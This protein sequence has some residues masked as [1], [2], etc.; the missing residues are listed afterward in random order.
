MARSCVLLR[1]CFL[2]CYLLSVAE[3]VKSR[4]FLVLFPGH[5]GKPERVATLLPSL[6]YYNNSYFDCL[7]MVHPSE[8]VVHDEAYA[9]CEV[10]HVK[11]PIDISGLIKLVDPEYI[12][13]NKYAAVVM[14][15]DDIVVGQDYDPLDLVFFM[16]LYELEVASPLVLGSYHEIQN[17]VVSP[18]H[19]FDGRLT[20]F[21]DFDLTVFSPLAWTCFWSIVSPTSRTAWGYDSC[22]WDLCRLRMGLLD[23]MVVTHVQSGG[24]LGAN[25][26]H[27]AHMVDWLKRRRD[28]N[29]TKF[30]PN[31]WLLST[32]S[33]TW[34]T[35]AASSSFWK[36]ICNL[37]LKASDDAC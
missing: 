35:S 32:D 29:H 18:V 19:R 8:Y 22:F 15:S 26:D 14:H 25:I 21:I 9:P 12:I 27:G 31:C 5:G 36:P 30:R 7:I 23:S 34:N 28:G 6:K 16:S 33:D 1:L 13:R 4:K 17:K 2:L 20:R 11:E 37:S 24:H 10:Y 3:S